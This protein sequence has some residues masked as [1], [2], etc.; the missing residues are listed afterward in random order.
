MRALVLS[1]IHGN[2]EALQ[3]VL[4]AASGW[5]ALWNL[6][7]IVG[8]GA[9]P[10]EVIDLIRPLSSLTVRGNHDRVC[11]GLTSP[12][13]FNPV[14][15]AAALWTREELTAENTEWLR[16][17]E[18]GPLHPAQPGVTCAHGSP[19]NEDQYILSMRDAWAPL[20]QMTTS[21]TFFGHTHLQGGFSQ[22]EH[23][24]HELR[25][26]Y[27]S[28]NEAG[29]WVFEIPAETRQLINPGSVGQPRDYDWRAAYAIYDTEAATITFHRVP[30][31]VV[32]AQGR[33][34]M[35]GLPERLA[36]RLREG[37]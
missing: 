15:R 26:A 19:L 22:K 21:I 4:D 2:L 36:L 32:R 8:Y 28:A 34:L 35:A 9:S 7:D 18:Q 11:C 5:D 3:A 14:A 29:S 30:Y 27:A 24:W 12:N 10:N 25:P 20:Q 17:L 23:D 13:G 16:A 37:R 6:G 31:D 1:D 33:I